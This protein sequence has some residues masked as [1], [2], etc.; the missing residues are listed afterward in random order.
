MIFCFWSLTLIYLVQLCWF[1]VVD[2]MRRNLRV[3]LITSSHFLLQNDLTY[4]LRF[5][6]NTISFIIFCRNFCIFSTYSSILKIEIDFDNV[7]TFFAISLTFFRSINFQTRWRARERFDS[8]SHNI[9]VKMRMWFD[10]WLKFDLV[11]HCSSLSIK[12]DV[13]NVRS[14]MLATLLF[15]HVINFLDSVSV[16][17]CFSTMSRSSSAVACYVDRVKSLQK[18]WCRLKSFSRTWWFAMTSSRDRK[19]ID[20][21]DE[22]SRDA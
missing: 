12:C 1:C 16:K 22:L 18:E 3:S 6:Q 21:I 10:N 11:M 17:S 15:S 7:R 4:R 9:R 14:M 20:K 19:T 5:A 2:Q 13:I 8:I